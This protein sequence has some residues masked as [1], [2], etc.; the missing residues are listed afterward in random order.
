M[1]K[2]I[3][4]F[5]LSSCQLL[6]TFWRANTCSIL[7]FQLNNNNSNFF[8]GFTLYFNVQYCKLYLP[9]KILGLGDRGDYYFVPS[10]DFKCPH[11][12]FVEI[13]WEACLLV[14]ENSHSQTSVRNFF[15][16]SILGLIFTTRICLPF[17]A[18]IFKSCSFY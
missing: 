15:V 1:S 10:Y 3:L 16:D 12:S 8:K 17:P 11:S 5:I 9:L 13:L 2:I 6:F 4:S 14:L 7:S 18:N